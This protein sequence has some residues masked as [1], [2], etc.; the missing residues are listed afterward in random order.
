MRSDAALLRHE[1]ESG[2]I[3]TLCWI[4]GKLNPADPLTKRGA[5]SATEVLQDW[6]VTGRLDWILRPNGGSVEVK[7]HTA[8]GSNPVRILD[9]QW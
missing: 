8:T 7:Q 9:K 5:S 3:E 4:K 6:M 1:H 2:K